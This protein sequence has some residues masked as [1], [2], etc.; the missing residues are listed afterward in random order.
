MLGSIIYYAILGACAG[1]GLL[2]VLAVVARNADL[3]DDRISF[4]SHEDIAATV[5]K[6]A[7]GHGYRVV[8]DAGDKRLY[9]KGHN[10]WTA[11]MFLEHQ[12]AGDQH[13]L[14]SYIQFN[15]LVARGELALSAP[16]WVGK[17]PR[18]MAK[19]AHN[20]LRQSLQLA[21]IA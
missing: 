11:P 18:S 20:A 9:Q 8:S 17:V 16:G 12:Q 2:V 1:F 7:Q 15:A 13:T 21:P 10:F 3:P 19:Q 14:R 4:T 5:A 6:W